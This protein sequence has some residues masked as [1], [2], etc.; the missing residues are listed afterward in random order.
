[1]LEAFSVTST[2]KTFLPLIERVENESYRF[3]VTKHGKPVAVILSY[4]EY[5]LMVET[6]HLIEDRG[7]VREIQEGSAEAEHDNT[8]ALMDSDNGIDS[9][10]AE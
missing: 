5:S 7:L 4:E 10:P 8:I 9:N 3:M 6:L 1:M 2:R